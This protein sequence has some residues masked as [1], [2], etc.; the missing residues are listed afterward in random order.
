MTTTTQ[1]T[2]DEKDVFNI[3]K[4]FERLKNVRTNVPQNSILFI[5]ASSSKL[6]D[7]DGQCNT[8]KI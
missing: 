2:T 3:I 4:V 5:I 7:K 6:S 1:Q 8:V